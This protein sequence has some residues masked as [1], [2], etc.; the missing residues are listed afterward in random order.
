MTFYTPQVHERYVCGIHHTQVVSQFYKL[1]ERQFI[2][3]IGISPALSNSQQLISPANKAKKI[4]AI[5]V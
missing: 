4:F 5:L 1:M 3:D 2:A